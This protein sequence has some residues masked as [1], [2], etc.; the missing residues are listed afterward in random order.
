MM[1]SS[2]PFHHFVDDYLAYLHEVHPSGATLDGV[3][4][5]DDHIEDLSRHGIEQHI[6]AL[7]GFSRRLQD[8]NVN[9]LTAVEKAEQPM[10]SANVQAQDVRAR[11]NAYLGAQ[12][13][14][15]RRHAVL[16]SGGA[17]R[18][19][20]RATARARPACAVEAEANPPLRAGRQRQREGSSG[21]LRQGRP[22]DLPR[23]A[24]LYREGPA[25]CVLGARRH[26]SARRSR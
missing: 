9:E 8:I 1:R 17:G 6:R 11:G 18:V 2:E 12:P 15:V 5:Y 20:S 4:T 25:A 13:A 14:V 19:Y 23:R 16:Q 3:H 22:R 26:A 7:A 10:V 21:N 24:E